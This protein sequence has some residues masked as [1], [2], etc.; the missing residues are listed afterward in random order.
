MKHI[1]AI[2][3]AAVACAPTA[4]AD[5][6]KVN[7]LDADPVYIGTSYVYEMRR[8]HDGSLNLSVGNT[9]WYE[10]IAWNQKVSDIEVLHCETIKMEIDAP[11]VVPYM[12]SDPQ[13]VQ[14]VPGRVYLADGVDAS[15]EYTGTI[16]AKSQ[17]SCESNNLV[18]EFLGEDKGWAYKYVLGGSHETEITFYGL[19]NAQYYETNI[20]GYPLLSLV[21]STTHNSFDDKCNVYS[22]GIDTNFY[23]KNRGVNPDYVEGQSRYQ[24][25]YPIDVNNAFIPR[26]GATMS[27][28]ITSLKINNEEIPAAEYADYVTVQDANIEGYNPTFKIEFNTEKIDQSQKTKYKVTVQ[29]QNVTLNDG[30]PYWLE[31]TV[32][33][34]DQ[35]VKFNVTCTM[36]PGSKY[37]LDIDPAKVKFPD[38]ETTG[39]P[40]DALFDN[41][42]TTFVE[43]SW[44]KANEREETYGSFLEIEL[45][46][47]VQE[48]GFK[49]QARI[50]P[51]PACPT[52]IKLFYSNDGTTWTEFGNVQ[53][54][55]VSSG[56]EI[57]NYVDEALWFKAPEKFKYLRWCVMRSDRG[58]LTQTSKMFYWNLSEL[59]FY[60]K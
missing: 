41:D 54:T 53:N 58:D 15:K 36:I 52:W 14:I 17:L 38:I 1:A 26:H 8:I 31:N 10:T 12:T 56:E 49:M 22:K 2:L 60:G 37:R 29:P 33:E 4:M 34:W 28:R 23:G 27:L 42:P 44:T 7:I 18:E 59:H 11:C 57:A 45:P 46:E 24:F 39:S 40:V 55:G 21:N 5:V 43:S 48:I 6:L 3:L 30:A 47:Q 13:F 9:D 32:G 16:L 25:E 51:N 35:N 50:L 20:F 19:M